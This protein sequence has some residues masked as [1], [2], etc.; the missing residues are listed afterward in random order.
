M[1]GQIADATWP[2]LAQVDLVLVPVGSIEQHGPHL[3]LDTDTAIATG[4]ARGVAAALE[5]A[6]VAP[7]VVYGSSGEHQ[8]FPGTSSVG[9]DALR[10]MLVE[11][12]RSMRT[13]TRR[14]LFVNAHGGNLR[15]LD[16]AVRQLVDE[17]HDVTWA[18]CA[19]EEV[20]LHAG[21]TETSLMLHLRPDSVRLDRSE[22]GNTQPLQEILPTL[23]TRG[24][25]AVSANGV[26]GDPTG[27]TAEEGSRLL[28]RMVRD[29]LAR[30]T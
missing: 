30:A 28:A 24:V 13:W 26:L 22:A 17:G 11:L 29:V 7:A 20:D 2:E 3:P 15:A 19:T 10:L 21:R 25:R 23:I 27:A 5:G 4:V 9:T 18:P 16:G 1:T 6:W 8:A 12:V 14:V